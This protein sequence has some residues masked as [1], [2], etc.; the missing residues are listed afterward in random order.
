[1]AD[2][3]SKLFD[4]RAADEYVAL[5][6]ARR[7]QIDVEPAD[8]EW[9]LKTVWTFGQVPA[10]TSAGQCAEYERRLADILAAKLGGCGA[11][12]PKAYEAFLRSPDG[13]MALA[14]KSRTHEWN[15]R[16]GN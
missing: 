7:D 15:E 14:L 6:A 1:M 10:V 12:D 8:L 16:T 2:D 3:A 5:V 9:F 13:I 4:A 11:D